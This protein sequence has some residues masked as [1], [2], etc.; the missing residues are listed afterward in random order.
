MLTLVKVLSSSPVPGGATSA[1]SSH[2]GP[3]S[4]PGGPVSVSYTEQ[5]FRV[6]VQVTIVRSWWF[7]DIYES[8]H[9]T[10]SSASE[11]VNF[12]DL[13]KR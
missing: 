5:T 4:I 13:D 8:E 2:S 9:P 11:H 10:G 6:K 3:S 7:T 1:S 12:Q